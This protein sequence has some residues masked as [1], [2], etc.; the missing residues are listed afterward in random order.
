MKAV[1]ILQ[2]GCNRQW[3]ETAGRGPRQGRAN[4]W[5]AERD[6]LLSPSLSLV[7]AEMREEAKGCPSYVTS[8][9]VAPRYTRTWRNWTSGGE[10]AQVQSNGC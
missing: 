10:A 6:R 3:D 7:R 8:T 4:A 5:I 9:R 2:A 1:E